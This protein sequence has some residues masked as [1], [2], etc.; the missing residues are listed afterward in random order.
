MYSGEHLLRDAIYTALKHHIP[1][2]RRKDVIPLLLEP[3]SRWIIERDNIRSHNPTSPEVETLNNRIQIA[4]RQNKTAKWKEIF[5]SFDHRTDTAKLWRTVKAIGNKTS[6]QRRNQPNKFKGKKMKKTFTSAKDLAHRFNKQFTI[7]RAH[8]T[9]QAYRTITKSIQNRS[10]ADHPTLTTAQVIK[11]LKKVRNSKTTGPDGITMIHLKH[12][13]PKANEHV[14]STFNLSLSR[15]QIPAIW[16]TSIIIPLLKPVKPTNKSASY[17]PISLFC[18]AVKIL[19]KCLLPILQE[20]LKTAKHQYG[21]RPRH[22]TVTALNELSTAIADGFNQQKPA[23][24][25]VL[26]ALDLS[27]TF[28]SVCHVTLLKLI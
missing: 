1:S 22:S 4:I 11:A 17:R 15:S 18:P 26:V 6:K 20:H 3:A 7:P 23:A 21:F 28:N 19:E 14:T 10:L 27:K 5:S 13:G 8:R 24:R 9:S 25:T 2:G 16:K 12:L